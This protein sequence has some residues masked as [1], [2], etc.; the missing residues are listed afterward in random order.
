MNE[1]EIN[2][3][4]LVQL[5]LIGAELTET[6]SQLINLTRRVAELENTE[7]KELPPPPQKPKKRFNLFND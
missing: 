5:R 6:K 1:V 7:D 4:I 2:Q 3:R